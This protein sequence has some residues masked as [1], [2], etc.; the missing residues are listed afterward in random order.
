MRTP[1]QH[2]HSAQHSKTWL[3][4]RAVYCAGS[5]NGTQNSLTRCHE[6]VLW[7]KSRDI[8]LQAAADFEVVWNSAE[9]VT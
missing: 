5:A 6:A 1:V 3:L 2:I 7:T 4:D 8:C 9:D